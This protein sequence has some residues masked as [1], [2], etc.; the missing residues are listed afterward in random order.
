MGV[1]PPAL[2]VIAG[3]N[4]SGK[5]TLTAILLSQLGIPILDPDA[6]VREVDEP[7]SETAALHAGRG[8][9]P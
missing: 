5:S 2:Y 9:V 6:V 7:T 3:P 4:G 8:A 1:T